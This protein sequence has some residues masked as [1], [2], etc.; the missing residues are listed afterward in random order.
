MVLSSQCHLVHAQVKRNSTISSG[1]GEVLVWYPACR[2][3]TL[4]PR[5]GKTNPDIP[6]KPPGGEN[7]GAHLHWNPRVWYQILS[8]YS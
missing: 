1:K 4:C 2:M 3:V 5:E 7:K 8:N 6:N